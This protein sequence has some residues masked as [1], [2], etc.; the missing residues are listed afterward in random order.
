V[1]TEAVA[2]AAVIVYAGGLALLLGVRGRRHRRLTGA[3]G[4]AGVREARSGWAWVAGLSFAGALI[5]GVVTPLLVV[6]GALSVIGGAVVWVLAVA[7]LVV[8]VAGLVGAWRAQSAMGSSWRIGVDDT[9]ETALVTGGIFGTVRNPI[10]TAMIIAQAGTV[11]M[12]PT[13]LGLVG[14]GL[15]V[16]SCQVQVRLVE[17]PYLS[18]HHGVAYDRYA[19]RTGRFLPGIGR[20]RRKPSSTADI[21]VL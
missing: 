16:V 12:V 2:V 4:F 11:V 9:E 3:S 8:A 17:E 13:W 5:I 18:T 6:L 15:L 14:V 7:G 1:T 10:F 21:G 19:A 20:M